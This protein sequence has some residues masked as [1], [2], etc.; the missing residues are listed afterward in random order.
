MDKY[1]LKKVCV[2]RTGNSSLLLEKLKS[3]EVVISNCEGG[4]GKVRLKKDFQILPNGSVEFLIRG[5]LR[6]STYEQ[7]CVEDIGSEDRMDVVLCKSVERRNK[8]K[9]EL[10]IY[11][12]FEFEQNI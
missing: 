8:K 9:E 1:Y 11:G 10:N 7:F 5:I 12:E 3:F 6:L 4:L 2:E